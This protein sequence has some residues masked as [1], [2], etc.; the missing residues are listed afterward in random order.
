M[1]KK[2]YQSGKGKFQYSEA[3]VDQETK[4][5]IAEHLFNFNHKIS[6]EDLQSV[7]TDFSLLTKPGNQ[8]KIAEK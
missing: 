7:K 8:K 4:K 6:A 1:P 5:K 3:F 2:E